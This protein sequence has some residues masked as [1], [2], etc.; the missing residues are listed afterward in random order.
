M[1]LEEK[2]HKECNNTGE[3]RPD[4]WSAPP[5][6][7]SGCAV[8]VLDYWTDDGCEPVTQNPGR[9]EQ[10]VTTLGETNFIDGMSETEML[11]MLEAIENA[12]WRAQQI[13][14]EMDGE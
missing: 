11:A 13:I 12:E 6:C 3:Q 7:G 10:T 2:I 5:C 14:A 1:K 9:T 8:C 4:S